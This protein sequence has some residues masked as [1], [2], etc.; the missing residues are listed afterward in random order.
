MHPAAEGA[1]RAAICAEKQGDFQSMHEYL[2]ENRTWSMDT[3]WT[4]HGSIAGVADTAQFAACL[5]ASSTT[6]RLGRDKAYARSLGISTTPSMVVG[7]RVLQGL[8]TD[9]ILL[10]ALGRP[11]AFP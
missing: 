8:Q 1:A 10:Q 3:S 11:E 2:L 9:A 5:Y 6:Q 7:N 4:K